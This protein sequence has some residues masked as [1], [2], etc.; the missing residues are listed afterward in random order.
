MKYF[1]TNLTA[2]SLL[3]EGPE[4][5]ISEIEILAKNL[6]NARKMKKDKLGRIFS[7]LNKVDS[8]PWNN[9][10]NKLNESKIL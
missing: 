3:N 7:P 10:S 1:K 9:K 5:L 4:Q 8:K 6:E 2:G